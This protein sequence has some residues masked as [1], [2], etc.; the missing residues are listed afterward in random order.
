MRICSH[1]NP[2]IPT[3][4]S[5]QDIPKLA[6]TREHKSFS[7]RQHLVTSTSMLQAK[8]TRSIETQLQRLNDLTNPQERA[9]LRDGDPGFFPQK[10]KDSNNQIFQRYFFKPN[11][12]PRTCTPRSRIN[13]VSSQAQA[14]HGQKHHSCSI[15][16]RIC[17]GSTA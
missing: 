1:T 2:K 16:M 4:K 15:E 5:S 17:T 7:H 12:H 13:N 3:N 6:L 14:R 9:R 8:A 11:P 10:S